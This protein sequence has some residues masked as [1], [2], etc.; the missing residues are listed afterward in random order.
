M[1]CIFLNGCGKTPEK[2]PP[3]NTEK[4]QASQKP[5]EPKELKEITQ[6]IESILQEAEKKQKIQENAGQSKDQDQQGQGSSQA[7]SGS[8]GNQQQSRQKG[9]QQD[10][11]KSQTENWTKEEKSVKSIH[12]KWNSLETAAVKAGAS[13]SL[14][15]E[16]ETNLDNLTNKVMEKSIM[17]VPDAANEL[18]GSTVKIAD[19]F[20]TDNPPPADMLKYFTQ[21]SL[22]TIEA[23]NWTEAGNNARE[24]KKHWEKVKTM[25]DQGGAQLNT[26]MDYAIADF[27]QSIEKKNKDVARIKGE[28]VLSNIEKIIKELKKK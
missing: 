5:K 28:I 18:Y 20:Q 14:I 7:Q 10:N 8:E 21:K 12:E 15:M 19:L 23:D 3:Q 1:L 26:Q 11:Q 24:L 16:F 6:E 27:E 25:M 17:E 13:D 9:A 4:Q 2:K 22:L